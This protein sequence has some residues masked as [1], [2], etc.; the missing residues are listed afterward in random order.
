MIPEIS[1]FRIFWLW[2][3]S[4]QG[5]PWVITWEGSGR[6]SSHVVTCR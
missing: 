3:F 5:H 2:Q 6:T 4:A 1:S